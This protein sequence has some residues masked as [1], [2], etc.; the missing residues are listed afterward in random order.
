MRVL[1]IDIGENAVRAVELDSAFGRFEVHDHYEHVLQ[2][3]EDPM[4][5]TAQLVRSMGRLP[6]KIATCLSAHQTIYRN[7][8]VPTANKKAI[9]AA[10]AFELEDEVPFEM[11]KGVYE[12]SILKKSKEGVLVHIASTLKSVVEGVFDGFQRAGLTPDLI[13][14]EGWAYHTLFQNILTPEERAESFMLI[15]V[16]ATRTFF[17]AESN[18]TP[19]LMKSVSWGG[20][21]VTQAISKRY[22]ISLEEAERAKLDNGFILTGA[23]RDS[24]TNDQLEFSDTIN[25]PVK[26]L[27]LELKQAHLTFKKYV[28]RYP[29]RVYVSGSTSLLPGLM[30]VIADD[31]GLEVRELQPLTM[32][33]HQKVDYAKSTDATFGLAAGLALSLC[34]H[35]RPN[36]VHLAR[37]ILL[38]RKG[39]DETSIVKNWFPTLKIGAIALSVV[40]ASLF[41]Q[42]W[43]YRSRVDDLN[44]SLETALRGFLGGA[45]K[46]VVRG[47][48]EDSDKLKKRVDKAMKERR[49]LE[50]LGG[51][52][53]RSPSDF[54]KSASKAIPSTLVVDLVQFRVGTAADAK[55]DPQAKTEAELTFLVASPESIERLA[56]YLESVMSDIK[57]SPPSEV[58]SPT[59]EGKRWKVTFQGNPKDESYGS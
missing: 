10:V 48:I 27:L 36:A 46:T 40:W 26:T 4:Q 23:A 22:R 52:N 51:R 54:L 7:I 39:G 15:R 37:S 25:E 56:K 47:L 19:I 29:H 38:E 32:L 41:V 58:P 13:T 57:R 42:D 49:E 14:T 34:A 35:E 44:T 30:N 28:Q 12:F 18:G 31:T 2:Q 6:E 11:D 9:R 33:S 21:D 24:A 17:Y 5:A 3:G 59:G 55:F 53:P 1:G 50:A 16:G 8:T 20:S 45:S 43:V